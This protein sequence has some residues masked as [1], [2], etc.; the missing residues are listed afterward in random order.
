MLREVRLQMLRLVAD[1]MP[2]KPVSD[3]SYFV[4]LR[5]SDWGDIKAKM[6]NWQINWDGRHNIYTLA[7]SSGH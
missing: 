1:A 4:T 3:T 2:T 6:S 7:P 5:E